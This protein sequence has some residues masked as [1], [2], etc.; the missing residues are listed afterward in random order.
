MRLIN[1]HFARRSVIGKEAP[2]VPLDSSSDFIDYSGTLTAGWARPVQ[3][4]VPVVEYAVII[5]QAQRLRLL[6]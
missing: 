5:T 3:A 2:L 1:R 4:G 6:T